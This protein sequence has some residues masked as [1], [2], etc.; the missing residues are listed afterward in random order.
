MPTPPPRKLNRPSSRPPNRNNANSNENYQKKV[1]QWIQNTKNYENYRAWQLKHMRELMPAI[2]QEGLGRALAR[3]RNT[4]PGRTPLRVY[5][6]RKRLSN[7][8]DRLNNE[9]EKLER[10][11]NLYGRMI[12]ALPGGLSGFFERKTNYLQRQL[13]A[14]WAGN[15][16]HVPGF[17]R[18]RE[19]I[20]YNKLAERI[21]R[22]KARRRIIR[23]ARIKIRHP[24]VNT[25]MPKEQINAL[26]RNSLAQYIEWA[27][28]NPSTPLGQRLLRKRAL[29]AAAAVAPKKPKNFNSNENYERYL[30]KGKFPKKNNGTM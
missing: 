9:I 26:R 17:E 7:E 21:N 11:R 10:S 12:Q 16:R 13:N 23:R 27:M 4:R 8:E 24:A 25:M 30:M 1:N 15:R 28:G 20:L 29:A 2:A 18:R 6:N 22:L 5:M 14:L 19:H 3:A